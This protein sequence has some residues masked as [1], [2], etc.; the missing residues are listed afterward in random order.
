MDGTISNDTKVDWTWDGVWNWAARTD[1][2]G[3]TVE[4][5]VPYDQLRFP[6]KDE[7]TWGIFFRRSTFRQQEIDDFVWIPKDESGLVSR[8]ARLEGIRSI[9]PPAHLEVTP[10]A[11]GRSEFK[12]AVP[13]DPFGAGQK[14]GGNLG[15]D[16]KVG[17]ATNLTLDAALNPDFGQVEVDPAVVNLTA[18]ETFYEEK[19]PFFIEGA[20]IFN[21]GQGNVNRSMSFNWSNPNFFYSRRIGR[22]PQGSVTQ[23]GFVNFPDR[24][25]IL[26]AAKISGKLA[27]VWNLGFLSALT[28]R[29]YAEIDS[30]G[31]RS[32]EEVE[33]LTYYGVMRGFREFNEGRQGIGLMSTAVVRDLRTPGLQ[34]ILN[35]NAFSL[36]ADGWAFLDAARTWVLNGWLG[37][38]QVKGTREEIFRLQQAPQHYFQRPDA[39]YLHLDPN[40]TSMS[41]WAGRFTLNK[42]SGNFMFNAALGAISPGFETND[43]GYHMRGDLINGHVALGYIQF[44]PGKI[45]RNWS[46]MLATFRHYDFGGNKISGGYFFFPSFQLLNYW[47]FQLVLSYVPRR[48]DNS[49]TRGGPLVATLPRREIQFQVESDDRKTI[50]LSLKS[51]YG[52]TES[53]SYNLALDF[54]IKWKIRSNI[55]FELGPGYHRDFSVVQWITRIPDPSLT[56]TY[57]SRYVFGEIKQNSVPV[58]LRLNWIFTPRASLQMYLQPFVSVGKYGPFKELARPRTFDFNFYGT[59]SSTISYAS[60]LYTVDPDGPG[61]AAPFSFPNPDFNLKSLRGTV[62]FRWEYAPGSTIYLVWTQERT[63]YAFPGEFQYGRDLGQLFRTAGD[64]IF[65]IKFSYRWNI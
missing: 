50:T 62:V 10:Y 53:G 2:E 13:G 63:D 60:G 36:A 7:Y 42:Q 57:G 25:T 15:A 33:P 16:V 5:R 11:V 6:N 23:D 32:E 12:P 19:R 34:S 22:Y 27:S 65:L 37:A 58:S 43:I 59:G 8:F 1:A 40:A 3:W 18:Y 14:F 49:L 61:P 9:N 48:L 17:L 39:T 31:R 47:S 55:S 51:D 52:R 64:N 35:K 26:S 44:K 41:G 24:T 45:F 30:A 29:E 21:F 54:I 20:G 38:S 4:I 46:A 56:A 28:G